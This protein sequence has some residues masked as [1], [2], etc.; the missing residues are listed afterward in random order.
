MMRQE[1]KHKKEKWW[2]EITRHH[3]KHLERKEKYSLCVGERKL[4]W[5]Y[6]KWIEVK[7]FWEQTKDVKLTPGKPTWGQHKDNRSHGNNTY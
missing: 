4:N 6:C 2:R 3:R 1:G 7:Q 5:K